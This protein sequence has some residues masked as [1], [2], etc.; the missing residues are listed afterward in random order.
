MRVGDPAPL[1][2][3][4]AQLGT[5]ARKRAPGYTLTMLSAD[6]ELED[7]VKIGMHEVFRTSNGGIPVHLVTGTVR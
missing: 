5:T 6:S 4:Y 2:N 7:Q 1:R 3:L